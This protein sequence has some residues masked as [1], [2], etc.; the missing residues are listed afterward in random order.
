MHTY[1]HACLYSK[2]IFLAASKK[3]FKVYENESPYPPHEPQYQPS[4][5][6]GDVE[7]IGETLEVKTFF[8]FKLINMII[9]YY[10]DFNFNVFALVSNHK[11]KFI[12][13]A[14]NKKQKIVLFCMVLLQYP[15][16]IH[17]FAL[18]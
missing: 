9:Y 2:Y 12:I 7:R 15:F 13:F 17:Y 8:N 18:Y 6:G 16:S 14:T 3:E 4:D 1:I 11:P 5:Q 10:I